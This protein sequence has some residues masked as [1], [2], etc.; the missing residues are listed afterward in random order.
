MRPVTAVLEAW[1]DE[2]GADQ[3][4]IV[5]P[6]MRGGRLSEDAVERLL[7]KYLATASE[8]CASL[9]KKRIT[10]HCLRARHTTAMGLLHAGVEQSVIVLWLGSF[11][12]PTSHPRT[13]FEQFRDIRHRSEQ[14]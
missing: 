6:S 1:L 3:D 14:P 10:F 8:A 12:P 7:K 13:L 4:G 5:F 2:T 11:I 9:K